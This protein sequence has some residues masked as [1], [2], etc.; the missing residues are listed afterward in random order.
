MAVAGV[1]LVVDPAA[2][3]AARLPFDTA[4]PAAAAASLMAVRLAAAW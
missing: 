4:A 1:P 3:A 2:D